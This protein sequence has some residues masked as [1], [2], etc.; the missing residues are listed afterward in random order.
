MNTV[1]IESGSWHYRLLV[2]MQVQPRNCDDLCAYIRK[3]SVILMALTLVACVAAIYVASMGEVLAWVA[4]MVL[5][6]SLISPDTF[7]IPGLFLSI[8]AL[9]FCGYGGWLYLYGNLSDDRRAFVDSAWE[10]IHD[11]VCFRTSF[12]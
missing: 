11:K 2:W 8:V 5:N 12:R 6:L 10:S 1:S 4:W 3:L 9:A 7:G